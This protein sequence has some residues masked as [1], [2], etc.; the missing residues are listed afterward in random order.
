MA[1]QSQTILAIGLQ[2]HQKL[3]VSFAIASAKHVTYM[4]KQWRGEESRK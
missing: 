3:T 1:R 2:N 4:M